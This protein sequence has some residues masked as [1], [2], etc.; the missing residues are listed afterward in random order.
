M[1]AEKKSLLNQ[2]QRKELARRLRSEDPGLEVMHPQAAGIDIGNSAHYVAVRPERDPEPVRR[3]ACFTADLHRLADW[4]QACGVETV[5]MQSTGVYWMPLYEILETR[6]FAVYLVNAR[7][8]KNLP[9]RK[10]DVQES[11]WLLKLHTYGLLSNSFQPP[12]EIRALRT[13]WRQRAEHIQGVATCIQR[14]Q[15]VLTQMNVQLANVISDLSG[16]TGQ[17]IVRAILAGERDPSKLAELSDPRIRA[18]R[19]EIAK[20]LEGN[21]QPELLFVL[22]QEVEM[23]DTYRQRIAECD[24]ELEAHLNRFADK[25]PVKVA[26]PHPSAE[27]PTQKKA[28]T[29]K[30]SNK[31]QGHAP[32]FDLGAELHRITGVDLTRIDGIDVMVAQTILSE[33]GLDMARWQTEAHFASWLGL[34]PDNRISGDRVLGKGTRHVVNRAATALRMAATAL[35]R[36]RSY[37]GAQYRRLR[38]RLGAPKAIT[39][40]AHKLAR[41]VYRMLKY[42]QEYVDKGMQYYDEAYRQQQIELLKKKAAKFGFLVVKARAA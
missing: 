23:Y 26:E 10:S 11:Q 31:A 6:G 28:R 24:Q 27:Q 15:K 7:H 8:T 32:Q 22:K 35:F 20:S 1:A 33:V 4:L 5:A 36:S 14:M 41:L 34:C 29:T 9:G 2:K 37:L 40:M 19:E 13:Y 18:T 42:G 17:K 25:L 16:V 38:T 39:A 21:W 12:A 3:F 30:H